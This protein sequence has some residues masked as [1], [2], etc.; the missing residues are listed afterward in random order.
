[1]AGLNA[2]LGWGTPGTRTLHLPSCNP[3]VSWVRI[4][5][6]YELVSQGACSWW[7]NL[8]MVNPETREAN[9]ESPET[10]EAIEASMR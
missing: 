8:R 3:T 10:R 7:L 6:E 1:M 4:T 5:M 2:I 9:G